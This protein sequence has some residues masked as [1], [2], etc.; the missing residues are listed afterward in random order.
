MIEDEYGYVNG[1]IIWINEDNM[2]N[3]I[4]LMKI[5]K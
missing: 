3:N 5:Q 4:V 1:I 2:I